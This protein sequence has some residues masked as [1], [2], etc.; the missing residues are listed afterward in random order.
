MNRTAIISG[1]VGAALAAAVAGTALTSSSSPT[2]AQFGM[3]TMQPGDTPGSCRRLLADG[4]TNPFPE[5]LVISAD[6]GVGHCATPFPCLVP[7][8]YDVFLIR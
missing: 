8:E 5:T 6:A 1:V 4:R 7:P 3:C 2:Q